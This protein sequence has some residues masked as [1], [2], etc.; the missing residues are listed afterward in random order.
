MDCEEASFLKYWFAGF[1][2]GL[3]NVDEKSREMV[4]RACGVAF[5]QSYTEEVFREAKRDSVDLKSFLAQLAR[6]FPEASYE[7]DDEHTISVRYHESA[8]DLVKNG[9]VKAPLLC[10]CSASNL[11]QNFQESLGRPVQVKL[12]SSI[13]GGAEECVFEAIL[14][15]ASG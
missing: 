14:S 10:K 4:L 9:W 5:A 1:I 15:G 3:E 11:Q 12:V 7:C 6:K 13:L 2:K 8:C